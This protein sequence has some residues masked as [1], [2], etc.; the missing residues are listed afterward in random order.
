MSDWL[1]RDAA[2][3]SE[4]AWQEIDRIA[5]A[6][7]KQTMVARKIA[8]F[9][10]PRGWDYAAKQLGTF[11]SAVPLRQTGSVRL[12]L[13]DVL[14]LA[15]IRRDFTISWSDIET[16]ERAGPPLEG[17]AIEEAAR[18]TA[19]AEDRLVFHGASGIPG[20]LTSHETPRLALSDW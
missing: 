20:I 10:G 19:L 1:R 5:A 15:E 18:E 11:Q 14:L 7:A 4:K 13:P 17:R 6:M 12:S 8:D 3:L 9:D 16:F 2:P